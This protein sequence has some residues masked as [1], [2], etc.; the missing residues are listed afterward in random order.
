MVR[1]SPTPTSVKRKRAALDG[2]GQDS[3]AYRG[4]KEASRWGGADLDR[5]MR[6]RR[7]VSRRRIHKG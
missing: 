6:M 7:G 3:L 2:G 4:K 1:E 5:A